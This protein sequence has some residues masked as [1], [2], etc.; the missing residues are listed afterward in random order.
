[1][2]KKLA[3]AFLAFSLSVSQVLAGSSTIVVKDAN[4]TTQTFDVTTDGSGFFLSRQVLCDSVAGTTCMGVPAVG[5]A[6]PVNTLAIGVSDGTT[7]CSG[8]ACLAIAK[9]IA[10]G[11]FGTPAV[12]VL[13]TQN[14]DPCSYAAKSSASISVTSA[15]TTSLVA[16]S[17]STTVYVCGL[18]MTIAPSATSADTAVIEYGTGAACTSPTALTG[19]LGNGDL[20]TTTG[21]AVVSYGS[22]GATVMKSASSAGICILS[23][24]TTVNIQGILTYVQQ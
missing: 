5:A 22:G 1:M 24:G 3:A 8:A 11:T 7:N 18:A 16:V 4:G 2:I 17:G 12:D 6:L 14:N 15:T 13:S 23:A 19:T 20:T 9:G 21:V 10:V